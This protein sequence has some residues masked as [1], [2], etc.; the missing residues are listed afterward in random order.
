VA[1]FLA[2][3]DAGEPVALATSG[4]SQGSRSVVR[5]TTSWV[6]SFPTVERLT[7]LDA[8]SRVWLPGPLT[9]TMNLFT[10]VHATMLDARLVDSPTAATHAVVTPS[11]LADLV[12]GG[13]PAGTVIVVAGDRLRPALHD[14]ALRAGLRVHHYYGSAELSFVAWG[15]HAGDLA[16]FPGVDVDVRSREIWVRTPYLCTGYD[17]PPGPLRVGDD[18]FATVGDRGELRDGILTVAGRPGAAQ[19]GGATVEPVEVEARLRKLMAAELAG[20]LAVIALPHGSLGSVLAVAMTD[21]ADLQ[22][23]RRAAREHLEGPQRPRLW[24]HVPRLP[25]TTAAKVDRTALISLLS[26][27]EGRAMRWV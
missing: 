18:G 2:A 6:S 21:S 9:A 17:G 22:A 1:A 5:T 13:L 16:A 25:L 12:A 27:D 11:A 20:D 7:G 14:E 23:T 24:F 3:H 4:T 8:T 19:V 15:S 26:G 10:A